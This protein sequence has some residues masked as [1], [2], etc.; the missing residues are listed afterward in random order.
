ME[1]WLQNISKLEYP[2]DLLMVDNSP[3]LDYIEKAKGYCVK[4][5]ITN[6]KIE[7]LEISQELS[8]D[9]RINVAQEVLRRKI[10]NSDYDAWFSWECDQIIPNNALNELIKLM[11][12]TNCKMALH[13]CWARFD[14]D[15]LMTDMGCTLIKKEC[16]KKAWFL[17]ER[18]GKISFNESD[19]YKSTF[20]ERVLRSGGG[21]IEAFGVISPIYHL[22]NKF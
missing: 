17:P 3:D 12:T 5:G 9:M 18:D 22:D 14:S 7:H 15:L 2:A 20:K 13:N 4:Y 19:R 21:F 11:E 16:L 8:S 10:L 1:R 6:Y